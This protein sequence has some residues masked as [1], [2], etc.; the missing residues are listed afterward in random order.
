MREVDFS[1]KKSAFWLNLCGLTSS[2]LAVV[3]ADRRNIINHHPRHFLFLKKIADDFA[4]WIDPGLNTKVIET[5]SFLR[6]SWHRVHFSL[7]VDE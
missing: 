2:S 1:S 4:D 7:W 3:V 5:A 6:P